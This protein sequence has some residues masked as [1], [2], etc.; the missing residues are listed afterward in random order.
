M[1]NNFFLKVIK[2]FIQNI[3]GP[4]LKPK[5]VKKKMLKD[6]VVILQ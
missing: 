5:D 4:L 1:Y 2:S 6:V 3:I